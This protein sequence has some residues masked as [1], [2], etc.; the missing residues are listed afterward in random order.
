[1]AAVDLLGAKPLLQYASLRARRWRT[2][3]T[4]TSASERAR[5]AGGGARG[6]TR[7]DAKQVSRLAVASRTHDARR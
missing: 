1:M 4:G 7:S 3:V 5:T 2:T 6:C